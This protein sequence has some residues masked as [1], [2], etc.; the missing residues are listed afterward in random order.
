MG[1]AP[2][3]NPRYIDLKVALELC[4]EFKGEMFFENI[5]DSPVIKIKM[6]SNLK[7]ESSAKLV[8]L[9]KGKP[10]DASIYF[11]VWFAVLAGSG[12]PLLLTTGPVQR[13]RISEE[14][15]SGYPCFQLSR[16]SESIALLLSGKRVRQSSDSCVWRVLYWKR[17]GR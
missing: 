4:K 8:S 10:R 6:K 7:K 12:S 14:W 15:M 9:K 3:I 5:D 16:W 1:V 2:E 13:W 11:A 17:G